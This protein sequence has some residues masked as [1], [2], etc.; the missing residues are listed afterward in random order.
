[1]VVVGVWAVRMI[2]GSIVVPVQVAVL[3]LDRGIVDVVVVLVV[4][5]VRVFVLD[6]IVGVLVPVFLRQVHEDGDPEEGGRHHG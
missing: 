2:V 6:W 1:M 4:V 5:T 3:A